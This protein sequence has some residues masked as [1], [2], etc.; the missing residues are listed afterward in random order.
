MNTIKISPILY[1]GN[2]NRLIKRG[3]I[4]LFPNNSHTFIDVFSGSA[5]LAMNFKAKSYILNDIDE[6]LHQYYN[7][8]SKYCEQVIINHIKKRI[9]EFELPQKTTNRCFTDKKEVEK[10]KKNYH[11]FR[12]NYNKNKNI[13]DLYTLMF[14]AFS[15]QIRVN[16]KGD[17]NMP[18]GNNHFSSQNEKNISNGCYFFS[19]KNVSF[20]KKDFSKLLENIELKQ[21][22]FVYFDPPYSITIASYNENNKWS[23][24]DD[25]R[26]FEIC[27]SLNKKG[28]K[29][30]LSNVFVNKGIENTALKEFCKD[31]ALNVFTP[32]HF[33]YHACGKKNLKQQEVYICNYEVLNTNHNFSKLS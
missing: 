11:Q 32:N 31:N 16:Q 24:K 1:M 18:F 26:L 13:F 33:Q 19:Q 6:T 23:K 14:F 27:E 8:F 5:A 30:G 17:F 20:Y 3:L 7:M 15:Q 22:D 12:E 2:K 21:D 29:F 25:V 4:S 28:I 10:Y 9:K